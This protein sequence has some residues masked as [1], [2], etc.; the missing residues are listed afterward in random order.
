MPPLRLEVFNTEADATAETV[1]IE[2]SALEEARLAAYEAGYKAGWEDAVA[3]QGDEQKLLGAEIARNLQA[4][5]FTFHEARTHVIKAIGPLLE[6]IAGTLL[7]EIARA[8][9]A[10]QVVETLLPLADQAAGAPITI[11]LNPSA[12]PAVEDMLARAAGLPVQIV[13]EPTLG[14]G[15]V[16]LRLGEAETH[17]DLDGAVA[18]I[19]DAI[20]RFFDLTEKDR[21]H[22]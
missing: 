12:R 5:S 22:G 1:V 10:P 18:T 21:R 8:T 19:A 11:C 7:P 17:V 13:E 3:A 14:E 15:Q 6:G 20:A 2:T 16:V 4:L 9:L